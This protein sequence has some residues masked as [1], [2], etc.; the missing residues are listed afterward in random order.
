MAEDDFTTIPDPAAKSE[1][2]ELENQTESDDTLG[3]GF[4][5]DKT[6]NKNSGA[7]NK[8]P[9]SSKTKKL[10]IFGGGAVAI[11]AITGIIGFLLLLPLKVLSVVNGL[12]THY[13]ATTASAINKETENLANGYM[14][15]VLSSINKGTCGSTIDATCVVTSSGKGSPGRLY[16][17]WHDGRLEQKLALNE[18]IVLGKKNG[19]LYM[20]INGETAAGDSDLKAVINGN[21]SIFELGGGVNRVS[22]TEVRQALDTALKDSSLWDKVYFRFKYSNLLKTKYGVKLC[23]IA[24]NYEDKFAYPVST[25]LKAAEANIALR[26]IS[27]VS[28]NYAYIVGCVISGGCD[29]TLEKAAAG[30]IEESSAAQQ[31]IQSTVQTNLEALLGSDPA[32]LDNIVEV[33]NDILKNG[34]TKTII[35]NVAEQIATKVFGETAGEATGE[36]AV[37]VIGW[38]FLAAQVEHTVKDIGP[39]LRI[40]GY[41]ASAAAAV[42]LWETY[43]TVA[44]E[45]KSGHMDST[46]LGSFT[47]SLDTNLDQSSTN[48]SDATQTPLYNYLNNGGSSNSNSQYKCNDGSA[49]PTGQLVCPEEQLDRGNDVAT[50]VSNWTNIPGLAQL[51]DVINAVANNPV[52]GFLTSLIGKALGGVCD[53]IPGC[54]NLTQNA[55]SGIFTWLTNTLIASP[56]S[57]NM[58][59]GRTYDMMAAGADVSYND[60]C[61]LQLGCAQL[62]SQQVSTIRNQQLASEKSEFDSQSLFARIFSTSSPY[63]LVSKIAVAIPSTNALTSLEQGVADIIG[64][65]VSVV[66]STFSGIFTSDKAFA[67]VPAQSDPF[68]VIQYGY[69]SNDPVLTT[70]PQTYWDNNCQG[71]YT[72]QWVNSQTQ[73]PNNGEPVNANTDGCMLLQSTIESDGTMFDSSLTPPTQGQ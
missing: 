71:D 53:I 12:E 1:L 43:N 44:S 42:N 36:A 35:A 14:R 11:T 16:T 51:A 26:V 8:I 64:D 31:A 49:V 21:K 40:M 28:Q 39:T 10:V 33:S 59:G 62:N 61:H 69:A 3:K 7:W 73:D 54:S 57:T 25:K 27:P 46:E 17:A 41:A 6:K 65:P 67:A 20:T 15:Q 30:D 48:Q 55:I 60:S 72:T 34:F 13:S 38:I 58:S 52:M 56:F 47:Q 68:G 19:Q 4:T 5:D 9:G 66:A 45:T 50:T 32:T 63:S 29:T 37:P 22:A 24:C 18:G 70:D 23:V 2:E